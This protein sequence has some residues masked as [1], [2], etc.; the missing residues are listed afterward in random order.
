[1]PNARRTARSE[2]RRRTPVV[3]AWP[4]AP[5]AS[6]ARNPQDASVDGLRWRDSV[7]AYG[8][9]NRGEAGPDGAEGVDEQGTAAA[10]V[11]GRRRPP[12]VH[13]GHV[14]VPADVAQESG[15]HEVMP[16]EPQPGLQLPR[17]PEAA[18]IPGRFR[19]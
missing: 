7:L 3:T 19:G 8:G 16:R 14:R 4:T 17:L 10:G 15:R 2:R 12:V 9:K 6:R 5:R 13:R 11:R 18:G 1:M